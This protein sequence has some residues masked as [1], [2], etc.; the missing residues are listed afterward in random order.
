MLF[1]TYTWPRG[2]R[3]LLRGVLGPTG[4]HGATTMPPPVRLR[5]LRT[6][7]DPLPCV[8]AVGA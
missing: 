3:S 4:Q 6:P 1:F 8:P 5:G 2:E 7:R